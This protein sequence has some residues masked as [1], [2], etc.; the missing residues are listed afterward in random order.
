MV[1]EWAEGTLQEW[2][3]GYTHDPSHPQYK[4]TYHDDDSYEVAATYPNTDV[5]SKRFRIEVSVTQL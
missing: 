1:K 5:G 3:T 2:L 4:I